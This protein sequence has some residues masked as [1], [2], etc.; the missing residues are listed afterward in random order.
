MKN[1]N[2]K[3]NEKENEVDAIQESHLSHI[4]AIDAKNLELRENGYCDFDL[5]PEHIIIAQR[6]MLENNPDYRQVLSVAVF[7]CKGKVW[8]YLRTKKG[9]E[10]SLH[11][12]VAVAVGGHWDLADVV[13]N[14]DSVIDLE[15]S[16]SNAFKREIKEEVVVGAKEVS[17]HMM[18]KLMAADITPTDRK[19]VAIITVIE[20]DDEKVDVAENQLQ[21][22]GFKDPQELLDGDYNLETWAIMV[23]ESL[24]K[25]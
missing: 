3:E 16:L 21:G 9:N 17:R 23:C 2:E 4:V 24:L 14:K 20:L 12:N 7:T 18:P 22:I 19:H 15:T 10:P 13:F 25:K 11:D 8:S 5:K 6:N 1:E